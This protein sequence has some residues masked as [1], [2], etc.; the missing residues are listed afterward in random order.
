MALIIFGVEVDRRGFDRAVS[1]I[2]LD[3]ADVV[4]SI[5]LVRCRRVSEPVG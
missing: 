4:A 2:F 3:V 5:G 1:E